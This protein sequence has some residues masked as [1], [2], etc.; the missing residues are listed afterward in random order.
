M[1]AAGWAFERIGVAD[2]P[3]AGTEQVLIDHRWY[4]VAG[5]AVLAV[6][7]LR[8]RDSAGSGDHGR[9]ERPSR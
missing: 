2:N 9:R 6:C 4:V 3:P 8:S 1:A 7:C 5:P